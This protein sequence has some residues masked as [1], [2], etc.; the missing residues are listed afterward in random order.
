MTGQNEKQQH[1]STEGKRTAHW[2]RRGPE[3]SGDPSR[4]E[5]AL[6]GPAEG[7]EDCPQGDCCLAGGEP[8]LGRCPR[9][10]RESVGSGPRVGSS[11]GAGSAAAT[12]RL[13]EA[14]RQPAVPQD[15]KHRGRRAL[16]V[17]E[18]IHEDEVQHDVEEA[19]AYHLREAAA[20]SPGC[21]SRRTTV[22][23]GRLG[24]EGAS[25]CGGLAGTQQAHLRSAVG[26]GWG[27]LPHSLGLGMGRD[28]GDYSSDGGIHLR[29]AESRQSSAQT[30]TPCSRISGVQQRP[31]HPTALQ[32]QPRSGPGLR[33][34]GIAQHLLIAL[35]E[36][37]GALWGEVQ[38]LLVM[39]EAPRPRWT[40]ST[41]TGGPWMRDMPRQGLSLSR[42]HRDQGVSRTDP[43]P[44]TQ[45]CLRPAHS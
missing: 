17:L 7:R 24:P 30:P 45:Q 16:Q 32:L 22:Q 34:Q 8:R 38:P 19:H 29:P 37:F 3:S 27:C 18:G 26:C 21:A 31:T 20:L 2:S 15:G 5:A 1:H 41:G 13:L 23:M 6:P 4:A 12:H 43:T 36:A 35:Q 40:R 28:W 14:V 42:S 11:V 39:G 9:P 44:G 25:A 33:P 10:G